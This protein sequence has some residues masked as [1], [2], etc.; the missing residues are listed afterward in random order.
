MSS[1]FFG[2]NIGKTGLYAYQ[3]ALNTTFHNITNSE[4]EGYCRQIVNRQADKALR[5]SYGMAGTGVAVIDITQMRDSYYDVKYRNTNTILSEYLYKFNHMTQLESYFNEVNIKGFTKAYNDMFDCLQELS[6][7]P[8]SSTVRT[9]V[10]TQAKSLTE[11]FNTVNQN[12]QGIQEECNFDIKNL[13]DKTNS[14]AQ[15]IAALTKQINALE[16]NGGRAND[17]RDQREL[18][19]DK[20][21]EVADISVDEN[22][23]GAGVGVTTYKVWINNQL[24]VENYEY[25]S[26]K[27]VP[28]EEKV[29]QND[30]KGLYDITWE[31]GQNFDNGSLS[32]GG[33]LQALF[34]VRDGN[35]LGNLTGTASLDPSDSKKVI[36]TDTNINSAGKLNIPEEGVI[37][38][39]NTKYKYN[40][41]KVTIDASGKYSYQFALEKPIAANAAGKA[42]S[43]GDSIE[44]K[45]IPYYQGQLNELVR[46]FAKEFNTLHRTGKDLD[47]TSGIDFFTAYNKVSGREYAFGQVEGSSSIYD[48][49]TFTSGTGAYYTAVAD[50]EPLYASYYLMTAQNFT[51]NSELLEEPRKLAT[52]TKVVDGQENNDVAKKMLELKRKSMFAQGTTN[53]FIESLV[54]DIGIDTA[55]ASNFTKAQK[56]VLSAIDNQRLS[57]SGVD[58]EEEAM[59]L[60]KYR[61]AYNMSAKVISVM[62]EIYDKLI[63]YMAV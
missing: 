3:S 9:Q 14:A 31:N 21:S 26:L 45:G 33:A 43:V 51:I 6:K 56:G 59:N 7:N 38:V 52:A 55:K 42:A 4:T 58:S 8:A 34:E 28:R 39:D 44:Y 35:A 54:D 36:L 1:T 10:I 62:D 61:S 20:L 60:I 30:I 25:N 46:T 49:S 23:V 29:N 15:Q 5:A 40:G 11:Y 63:N 16:I 17:L 57:I 48:A 2:L 32:M 37:T 47:N 41:F 18:L 19:I 24:L 12:L 22:T 53:E 13:V 50:D 27:V